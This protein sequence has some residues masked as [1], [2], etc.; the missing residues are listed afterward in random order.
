[1]HEVWL[2][3]REPPYHPRKLRMPANGIA[4]ETLFNASFDG[5][6]L[7]SFSGQILSDCR[8]AAE[9][10]WTGDRFELLALYQPDDCRGMLGMIEHRRWV[11]RKVS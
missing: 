11:A 1:M 2:A 3:N 10:L 7:D 8:L 4:E 9:W 5:Q 6:V